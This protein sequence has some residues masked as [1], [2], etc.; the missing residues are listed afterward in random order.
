MQASCWHALPDDLEQ[1][2]MRRL[3]MAFS[4]ASLTACATLPTVSGKPAFSLAADRG[5]AFAQQRC[6]GCHMVGLDETSATEGPR[7]RDL[8]MR[9]TSLSLERRFREIT[10]HGTGEMPPVAFS[11]SDAEDLIAY[12]ETLDRRF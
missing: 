3:M 11:A 6:S 4:L 10:Q 12:F 9:Y 8:Q 2:P 5:L 7:F 1:A